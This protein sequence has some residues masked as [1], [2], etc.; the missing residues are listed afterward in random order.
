MTIHSMD[1]LKQQRQKLSQL[2]NQPIVAAQFGY[3]REGD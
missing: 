1:E 3:V 2:L